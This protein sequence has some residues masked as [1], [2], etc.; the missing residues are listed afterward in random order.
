VTEKPA[1][2]RMREKLLKAL[3][4]GERVAERWGRRRAAN[5]GRMMIQ[6]YRSYGTPGTLHVRGRVLHDRRILPA[7]AR[8][9]AVKN[10]TQTWKRVFSAEVAGARVAAV[11]RGKQV[12]GVSDAEGYF[13]L[14]IDGVELEGIHLWEQVEVSILSES[15]KLAPALVPVLVPTDRAA[16]GIVSDIDDTVIRTEATSLIRMMR[17]VLLDNA[18]VRLPFE[19]VAA[20]YKALHRGLNPIFYVSSGPW[21]LYDL[22]AHVFEIRGIP[23]GPIFLQD[24]GLE[25]G[26][27]LVRAHDDHKTEQIDAVIGTYPSLPFILIGDSGQRDPEI[28]RHVV[29]RYPGRILAI[30]IRDVTTGRRQEEVSALAAAIEKE[31]GVPALL[32]PDTVGAAK[33]AAARGWIREEDVAEIAGEKREDAAPGAAL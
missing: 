26:K 24:W 13:H 15:G 5:P 28:Y 3:L 23:A 29:R 2:E 14:T 6:P 31:S 1:G 22:L 10:F 17:T 8:D 11:Y 27:L 25:E 20:F 18:H 32:V 21:N 9:T 30:Y 19:G 4:S 33:H 16:F 12:E 7:T